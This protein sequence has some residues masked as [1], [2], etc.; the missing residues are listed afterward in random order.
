MAAWS[1]SS[2]AARAESAHDDLLLLCAEGAVAK[3]ALDGA[4]GDLRVPAL[5]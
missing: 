3:G 5:E 2:S 1:C 4:R